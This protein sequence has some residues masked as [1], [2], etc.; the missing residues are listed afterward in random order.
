MYRCFFVFLDVNEEADEMQ[1]AVLIFGD[2]AVSSTSGSG[3]KTSTISV[4]LREAVIKSGARY[5]K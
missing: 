5:S 4:T 2:D 1:E 3:R